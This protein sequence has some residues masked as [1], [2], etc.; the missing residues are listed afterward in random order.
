VFYAKLAGGGLVA[1]SAAAMVLRSAAER[2]RSWPNLNTLAL[3]VLSTEA[4]ITAIALFAQ[5]A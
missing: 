5:W 2:R 3:G 1:A 4:T